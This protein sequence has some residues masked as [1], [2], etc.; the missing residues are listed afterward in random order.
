M[1]CDFEDEYM[2]G[3]YSDNRYPLKW[4]RHRHDLAAIYGSPEED[5]DSVSIGKT[6]ARLHEVLVL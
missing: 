1:K 5:G 3:Y 4:A 2:C 6:Q